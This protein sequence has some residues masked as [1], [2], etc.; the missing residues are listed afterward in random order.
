[1]FQFETKLFTLQLLP[2][3]TDVYFLT[4][5]QKDILYAKRTLGCKE[6]NFMR[7][8]VHSAMPY[9]R[10]QKRM[11]REENGGHFISFYLENRPR[12]QISYC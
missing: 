4:T 10:K 8:I 2:L 7:V 3:K 5:Q 6:L 12:D 9:R 1:M 11:N